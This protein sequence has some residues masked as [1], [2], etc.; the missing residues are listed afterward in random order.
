MRFLC[1]KYLYSG[2]QCFE[3]VFKALCTKVTNGCERFKNAVK[4]FF[5]CFFRR[6]SPATIYFSLNISYFCGNPARLQRALHPPR[7]DSARLS[8][9]RVSTHPRQ[10]RDK[11]PMG[12]I[13]HLG[14]LLKK[15]D[16]P[17]KRT[18]KGSLYYLKKRQE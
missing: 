3:R 11:L 2:T 14:R 17:N 16:V 9:D 5:S 10:I 8:R 6:F 13:G 12:K 1:P 4:C 15:W 18:P 7:Q